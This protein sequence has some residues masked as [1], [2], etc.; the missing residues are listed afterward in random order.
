MSDKDFI[1]VLNKAQLSELRRI[2]TG[3][4]EEDLSRLNNLIKDP[5][6]FSDHII[7]FLPLS[8][9]KLISSHQVTLD[10]ITPFIE[11]AIQASIKANPQKFA[12]ILY[13]VMVPAIR[14]AVAE[15]IKRM[16][17]SVSSSVDNSFSVKRIGW[18]LQSI[19]SGKSYGEIVLSHAFIYRVRE[20]FLIHTETGL[21]L[22]DITDERGGLSNNADMVS[23]MLTAIKDFAQDSLNVDRSKSDLNTI[24]MG[25]YTIWIEPGPYAIVAAIIEGR[26][27]EE[28]KVILKEAIEAVHV[29]FDHELKTF[30]G[31]T[32]TFKKSERFLQSCIKQQE[33]EQKKKK[34]I[35]STLLL[36][37]LLSALGY[38][39]YTSVDSNI[40]FNHFV[41]YAENQPGI[42]I[43]KLEKQNGKHVVYALKDPL[44]ENP[45]NYSGQ[46]GFDSSNLQFKFKS[47]LS[48][49]KEIILKRSSILLQAFNNESIHLSNG[50][51]YL[52]GNFRQTEADSM[53][54][55]LMHLPGIDSINF[56]SIVK[57]QPFRAVINKSVF[58]I[59][60]Y[61]FVFKYN[62]FKLDSSQKIKF[63]KLIK[64]IKNVYDFNF[65]NDSIPVIVVI[66][67]TSRAGNAEGNKIVAFNRAKQFID[68]M[69]AAGIPMETLVPTV[70]YKE[71]EKDA[72]PLR[73]V[74]FKV[75]F[76]KPEEL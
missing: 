2:I 1:N 58:N 8:I 7:E 68:L 76:V 22:L 42:V 47:Y 62:T 40:R 39:I 34:P 20:V 15:D 71:E 36:L 45:Y 30:D 26:P 25:E 66:A 38:W 28:L 49:E 55:L 27:P 3:L 41:K 74:S 70:S 53:K 52:K 31:D 67:H 32:D 75:K 9:K 6:A 51:I 21:L 65:K 33:K 50:I 43:N 12:N 13:P 61:Y 24:Q 18:R 73:S 48:L 17:D 35:A 23:S 56:D 29:N 69:V 14:K 46:F 19:F 60:K 5:D 10:E 37:I 11:Q 72:Y 4:D 64:N 16:L 54:A 44:S 63:T 59:E 57:N